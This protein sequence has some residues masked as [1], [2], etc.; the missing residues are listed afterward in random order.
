[1]PWSW[2]E[3]RLA[4][5]KNF[6]LTTVGPDGRPHSMPLWGVWEKGEEAFWFSCAEESLKVRNI[7]SNPNV[8]VAA[9]NTVEVVSVE[10][11]A[12]PLAGRA[13]V[14]AAWGA[15]YASDEQTKEDLTAFFL[16]GAQYVVRPRKAFG[17]IERDDEFGP[18]ATRWVW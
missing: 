6:W 7:A 2:A 11:T 9:D 3:K 1:M 12:E 14:A 15:K 17:L 16:G 18:K 10:G 13:D 5:S 8:V 4:D